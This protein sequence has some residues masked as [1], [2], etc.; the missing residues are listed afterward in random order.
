[1]AQNFYLSGFSTN[2]NVGQAAT[3]FS[4]VNPENFTDYS[5]N[6]ICRMRTSVAQNMFQR[7]EERRRERVSDTV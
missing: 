7:S 3:F 4:V 1:M 6:V 2:V 5:A